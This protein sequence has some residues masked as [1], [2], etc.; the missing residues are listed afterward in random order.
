MY[1]HSVLE[2]LWLRK[3]IDIFEII[4]SDAHLWKFLTICFEQVWGVRSHS[5]FHRIISYLKLTEEQSFQYFGW[6]TPTGSKIVLLQFLEMIGF[7]S[8]KVENASPAS[9]ICS[10]CT[11]L[12]SVNFMSW[13][14][15]CSSSWPLIGLSVPDS[16]V[17]AY[18]ASAALSKHCIEMS[19]ALFCLSIVDLLRLTNHVGLSLGDVVMGHEP[20]ECFIAPSS[21]CNTTWLPVLSSYF[22]YI[23]CLDLKNQW[24]TVDLTK[25]FKV[26]V[27]GVQ[28][29]T[30]PIDLSRGNR[31][32][33]WP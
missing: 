9:L 21:S 22:Q 28:K 10:T 11:S 1:R 6:L 25:Y 8:E 27:L 14:K 5:F 4:L 20:V 7:A 32:G 23:R 3:V 12:S 19:A 31:A 24:W 15:P 18:V 13:M 30:M 33:R 16:F 26:V 29:L 17:L 2:T